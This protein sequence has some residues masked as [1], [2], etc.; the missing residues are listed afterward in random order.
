MTV[1]IKNRILNIDWFFEMSF[2]REGLKSFTPFCSSF[3]THVPRVPSLTRVYTVRCSFGPSRLWKSRY[4]CVSS[5]VFCFRTTH[6]SQ[7]T[8]IYQ[9]H[10]LTE[11]SGFIKNFY[12][13]YMN[14]YAV[15]KFLVILT[16]EFSW[17]SSRKYRFK[18]TY[19]HCK[20]ISKIVFFS[21]SLTLIKF[22]ILYFFFNHILF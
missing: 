17:Y 12:A 21:F 6:A 14:S 8:A 9:A 22:F 18:K 20:N 3:E 19:A 4:A 1:E 16:S 5:Y 11:L 2:D 13:F 10:M 7:C 15:T